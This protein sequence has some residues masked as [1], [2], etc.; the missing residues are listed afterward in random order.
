MSESNTESRFG[1]KHV[2]DLGERRAHERE[3]S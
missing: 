2:R 3:G 1:G